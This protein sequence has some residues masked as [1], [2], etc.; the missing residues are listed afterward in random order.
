MVWCGRVGLGRL[1]TLCANGGEF[2]ETLLPPWPESL[3]VN[4]QIRPGVLIV[5]ER[6]R[7]A[8]ARAR[9]YVRALCTPLGLAVEWCRSDS[10]LLLVTK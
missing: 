1:V 9:T 3:G 8:R 4:D 6:C 10:A 7:H 2:A 5:A